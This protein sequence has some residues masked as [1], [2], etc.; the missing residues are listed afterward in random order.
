[1]AQDQHIK[2]GAR[3]EYIGPETKL[4]TPGKVYQ[5]YGVDTNAGG[6]DRIHIYSDEGY[7]RTFEV[8]LFKPAV[9]EDALE[10]KA[11]A[12]REELA[13]E[14]GGT[15]HDQGKVMLELLPFEALEAVGRVMTFGAKKYAAHNW[16]GGFKFSR[17]FGAA[18]R[19]GFAWVKGEDLDP[20]SGESHLAHMA[21]CILFLLTFVLTKTG[22]DDRHI[23]PKG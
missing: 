13:Q 23:Y 20:E 3:F 14:N 7:M 5:V 1:M 21:C 19:H 16:R 2:I 12:A 10:A 4:L 9:E 17:V 6:D 18:L 11:A 8:S 22:E 15:K